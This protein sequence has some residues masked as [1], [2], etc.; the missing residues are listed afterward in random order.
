M[1]IY[2]IVVSNYK[3]WSKYKLNR[4][5]W[6]LDFIQYL[7]KMFSIAI[8]FNVKHV[9]QQN[10][11]HPQLFLVKGMSN[12]LC[13]FTYK[14]NLRL[15]IISI[16]VKHVYTFLWCIYYPLILFCSFASLQITLSICLSIIIP[17]TTVL[18]MYHKHSDKY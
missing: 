7:S 13:Y 16:I 12:K 14:V 8:N 17:T 3:N 5:D 11:Y 6:N 4:S 18:S 15:Y 10:C 9:Y 2:K 1:Y